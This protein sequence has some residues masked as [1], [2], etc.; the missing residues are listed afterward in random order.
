MSL[1]FG[2]HVCEKKK[3]EESK[4]TEKKKRKERNKEALGFF[5]RGPEGRAQMIDNFDTISF[6]RRHERESMA[7]LRVASVRVRVLPSFP[8]LPVVLGAC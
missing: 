4:T 1:C 6:L 7:L 5:P 2:E 8:S 3:N